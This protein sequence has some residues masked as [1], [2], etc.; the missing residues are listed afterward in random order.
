[1]A[2]RSNFSRIPKDAYDTPK[3]AVDVLLRHIDRFV[4]WIEPAAG[5]NALANALSESGIRISHRQ[6]IAPRALGIFVG[7]GT[8]L[9][10][11]VDGHGV[12]TNPPFRRSEFR[13]LLRA[14]LDQQRTCWILQPS[15]FMHT[16]WF[17]RAGFDANMAEI[18]SLPRL[19]W[20]PGSDFK[21]T[22]DH[23]WI[24]YEPEAQASIAFHPQQI[25]KVKA[26]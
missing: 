19:Q 10:T 16:Q 15:G 4:P 11:E 18:V 24:R 14:W 12:A 17:A 9:P 13:R 23:V 25:R 8:V 20:I 1:M 26:A 21:E 6:D 22:T 5:A 2:K 7:D 3:E